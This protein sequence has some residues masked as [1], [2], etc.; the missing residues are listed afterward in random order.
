[1][2]RAPARVS[3]VARAPRGANLFRASSGFS[4]KNNFAELETMS[5]QGLASLEQVREKYKKGT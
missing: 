4:R 2:R 1:M 3:P 5:L